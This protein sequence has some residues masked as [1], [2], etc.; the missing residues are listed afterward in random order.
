MDNFVYLFGDAEA[1]QAA[2]VDPAWDAAAILKQLEEDGFRL[3]HIILSHGHYDH[4]NALQELAEK[5]GATV[6][7][8]AI[9]LEKLIPSGA[10]GLAIPR[11]SL[12]KTDT[13]GSVAIGEVT[14]E[15]IHTPGHAPG[16]QCILIKSAGVLFTGDTLF[17]GTCGRSDLP[18]SSPE[19]LFHSLQRIKKLDDSTMIYP[20]HNYGAT[21]CNS[22]KNE[23]KTNPF[24]MAATLEQFLQLVSR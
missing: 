17:M 10:G 8:Q 11:S 21:P 9:E 3:T 23:K 2:V 12:K 4:I 24:L 14:A 20:G 16:S 19:Q 15:M 5:T 1:R 18:L 7:A 22:L 6:C 13:S